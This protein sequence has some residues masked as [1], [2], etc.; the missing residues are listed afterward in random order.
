M[1]A[2]RA[3]I[4][5]SEFTG[6]PPHHRRIP[7][8][9]VPAFSRNRHI[10]A[11][12]MSPFQLNAGTTYLYFSFVKTLSPTAPFYGHLVFRGVELKDDA[13]P[14]ILNLSSAVASSGTADARP[15]AERKASRRLW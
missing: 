11:L 15:A 12:R 5:H 14:S 8:Y 3:N 13:A 4:A 9:V 6:D 1:D 2:A 10:Q 7:R